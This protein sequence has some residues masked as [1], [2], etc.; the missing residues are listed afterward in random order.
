MMAPQKEHLEGDY[1]ASSTSSPEYP[2]KTSDISI[3]D[4]PN[5]DDNALEADDVG[6]SLFRRMFYWG[7]LFSLTIIVFIGISTIIVSSEIWPPFDTI[8]GFLSLTFHF[9]THY[10]TITNLIKAAYLGP[11]YIKLKWVPKNPEHKQRLQFCLVCEGYKAP[12]SHHCSQCNRCVMKMEHHCPWINNCVGHRNH[13]TFV[14]FMFYALLG[15]LQSMTLTAPILGRTLM[16]IFYPNPRHSFPVKN[17]STLLGALT[18]SCLALG[19][20]IAVGA[21]FFFQVFRVIRTNKTAVEDYICLKAESRERDEPFVYP[22]D[23]GW[24]RN[25]KEVLFNGTFPKGN[26]IWWP[27]RADCHQFTFSEEQ[28]E[29]KKLKHQCARI[30]TIIKEYDGSKAIGAC[31]ISVSTFFCQPYTDGRRLAVKPGEQ[32]AITRGMRHWVYGRLV[33]K[34]PYIDDAGKAQYEFVPSDH[35][36]R[37]WFPRKCVESFKKTVENVPKDE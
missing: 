32:Y 10:M 29:Q 4:A 34:R 24:K 17:L 3:L 21:L 35:F 1:S 20:I 31:R 19:V 6:K 28:I 14:R 8:G 36:R 25:V 22:Y 33:E 30:K 23:L 9:W 37:G 7:P 26:G 18:G 5:W 15:C 27:V 13:A 12:R 16:A 11:G 2:K